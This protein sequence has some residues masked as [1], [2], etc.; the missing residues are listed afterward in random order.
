MI[1]LYT[2]ATPN[3]WK[4]SI[5]LEELRV[6]HSVHPISFRKLEQKRPE[7]RV[8]NPNAVSRP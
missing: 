6:P 2:W 5:L 1:D 3:G 4:A 7:Y 8:L